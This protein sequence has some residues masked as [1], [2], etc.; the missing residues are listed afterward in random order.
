METQIYQIQVQNITENDLHNLKSLQELYDWECNFKLFS[1]VVNKLF[2][3]HIQDHINEPILTS[4][5]VSRI[6]DIVDFFNKLKTNV[7]ENGSSK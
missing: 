4:E 3:T 2:Y 5:E 6:S 1:E 7:K